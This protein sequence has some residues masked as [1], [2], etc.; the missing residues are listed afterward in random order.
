VPGEPSPDLVEKLSTRLGSTIEPTPNRQVAKATEPAAEAEPEEV[1]P[2]LALDGAEAEV[3]TPDPEVDPDAPDEAPVE[4]PPLET[5]EQL[6]QGLE[7]T[8]EELLGR[9]KI[10]GVDGKPIALA[11]VVADYRSAHEGARLQPQVA[12]KLAEY[13]NALG[14]L[15]GERSEVFGKIQ[16]LTEALL[17]QVE[18]EK[19]DW[20]ALKAENP[21]GY[22]AAREQQDARRGVVSKA[23][24]AM[25]EE[26]KR[27]ESENTAAAEK[28]RNQ[29][30]VELRAEIPDFADPARGK[31]WIDNVGGYVQANFTPQQLLAFGDAIYDKAVLKTLHKAAMYDRTVAEAAKRKPAGAPKSLPKGARVDGDGAAKKESDRMAALRR[32]YQRTG[33]TEDLAAVLAERG[34]IH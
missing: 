31:A 21:E 27:V 8:E 28:W 34:A 13:E 16:G 17:I 19:I 24:Q 12:A 9:L 30:A 11:Q 33:K 3:A 29:Q 5:F 2:E 22:I 6:A 14:A 26:Q 23:L 1:Q 20:A 32:K 4:E 15:K 10:N 18:G 25:T 7:T